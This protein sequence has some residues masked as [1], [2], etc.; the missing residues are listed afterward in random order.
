MKNPSSQHMTSNFY[1][2]LKP[3]HTAGEGDEHCVCNEQG[4]GHEGGSHLPP[5]YGALGRLTG[6]LSSMTCWHLLHRL[7]WLSLEHS[8][9]A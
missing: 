5:K 6:S 9:N 4:W 1:I 2:L 8:M 3:C 7:V